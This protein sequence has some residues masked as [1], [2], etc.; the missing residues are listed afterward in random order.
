LIKSMG[1]PQTKG[2]RWANVDY[3]ASSRPEGKDEEAKSKKKTH[4]PRKPTRSKG[5]KGCGSDD[6][7]MKDEGWA[8][9]KRSR[10]GNTGASL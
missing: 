6:Q 10:E 3:V 7:S 2:T 8:E 9:R 1:S 5:A 4:T